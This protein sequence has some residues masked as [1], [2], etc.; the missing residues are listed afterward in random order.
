MISRIGPFPL[1]LVVILNLPDSIDMSVAL[2]GLTING[3]EDNTYIP[4][5]TEE[6][7]NKTWLPAAREHQLQWIRAFGAGHS[8]TREDI[9]GILEDLGRLSGIIEK[10]KN[11]DEVLLRIKALHDFLK[12]LERE[13][14]AVEFSI[15]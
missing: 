8:F 4:V 2:F 1:I 5:A 3:S 14:G 6:V 12:K 15:G 10:M 9:A 11:E 7:F 13:E